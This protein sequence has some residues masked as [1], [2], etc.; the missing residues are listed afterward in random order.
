MSDEE[1]EDLSE[2]RNASSGRKE[3][4]DSDNRLRKVPS[5]QVI[6]SSESQAIT[7]EDFENLSSDK[8]EDTTEGEITD[9][10]TSD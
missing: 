5:P 10:H 9:T 3:E 4:R 7:E 8:E 2:E 6:E 1:Q